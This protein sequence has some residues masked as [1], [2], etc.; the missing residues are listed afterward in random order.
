[1]ESARSAQPAL[2]GVADVRFFDL[3]LAI[4]MLAGLVLIARAQFPAYEGK[5]ITP[6]TASAPP[7][8]PTA[9]P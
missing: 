7:A 2:G 6:S 3:I 8:V 5:A 4:L 1:M 9:A